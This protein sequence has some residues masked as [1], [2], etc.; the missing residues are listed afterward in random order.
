MVYSS[1]IFKK[2][3]HLYLFQFSNRT[4]YSKSLKAGQRIGPHDRDVLS[5]LIGN[6]LGDAYAEM[7]SGST[8]ITL[9]LGSPNV[10]YI[11]WLSNFYS[12]RGYSQGNALIFR[13]QLGKG[14]KIYFSTKI[15]TFSFTSL[16]WLR[17]DFYRRLPFNYRVSNKKQNLFEKVFPSELSSLLTPLALSIW[18]MDDGSA[19]NQGFRISTQS[20]SKESITFLQKVLL[21][22]YHI[23]T[24]LQVSR[25]KNKQLRWILYFPKT[26]ASKL[27]A[28]ISPYIHKSM[29]YK[30]RQIEKSF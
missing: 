20:F 1:N 15:N 17:F 26:E 2:S 7:R 22:K 8:R 4:F 12:E 30:F 27:Y 19:V 3:S 28:S 13:R 21:E 5:V 6:L 23:S 11:Q 25:L 29:E 14:G 9:H 18:A 24:T 10:Q 16:N